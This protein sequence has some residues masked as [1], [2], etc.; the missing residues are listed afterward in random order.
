M[1]AF[2]AAGQAT[3][4][5]DSITYWIG[6]QRILDGDWLLVLDPVEVT[7]TPG[8]L[9]FVAVFRA[10]CGARAL[11][12][13]IAAQH[14]LLVANALLAC[15][16]CWQLTKEKSAVLL[17]MVVSLACLS[18]HGVA[19]TLLSDTLLSFLVT[20]CVACMIS[21]F[22]SP[23]VA[24]AAAIGAVL[25]AAIMVKPVAQFAWV[26]I[27]AVM[28]VAS[29]GGLSLR[30]RFVHTAS[31][32]VA[33]G[34]IVGPWLLRNEVYFG[35]PFLTKFGGRALWWSC[36]RE[37]P[38]GRFNPPIPFA[39][40]GPAMQVIRQTV[41]DVDPH[42]TWMIYKALVSHG[43]SP[44]D[45]DE[46]MLRAAKEAV[47]SHFWDYV[48]TRCV[49]AAWFWVTPNGTFRPNTV[50]FDYGAASPEPSSAAK[51]PEF[52]GCAG[53][54]AW[55]SNWYF[56]K[57]GMNFLWHPHPLLYGIAAAVT[58]SALVFLLRARKYRRP[59]IFFA[60]WLAYFCAVTV[61]TGSPEYRYRMI[62]EPTMI[63]VV[64]T[65]WCHFRTSNLVRKSSVAPCGQLTQ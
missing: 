10:T 3:L 22:Q 28:L 29:N 47:R 24:K 37:S 55:K 46:L 38:A 4:G 48:L 33:T 50:D 13:A 57:G 52:D 2:I 25:G 7:R 9:L 31:F 39:E 34:L 59:A 42:D 60:L 63:I 58:F 8:Y 5:A 23:S 49:R 12:A 14:V 62:L 54:A 56:A 44:I 64:V 45:A 51:L 30:T 40:D 1:G 53:Q 61:V 15:W 35:S 17:C 27:V 16:A 36:F 6:G 18:C 65:A 20:L 21:W 43:F 11:A 26:P 32:L 41:P 19:V